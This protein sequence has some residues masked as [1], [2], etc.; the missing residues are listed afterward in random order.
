MDPFSTYLNK[1]R[2]QSRDDICQAAEDVGMRSR[3]RR[4]DQLLQHGHERRLGQR[5]RRGEPHRLRARRDLA[6]KDWIKLIN[7]NLLIRF[8]EQNFP[9]SELGKDYDLLS[10]DQDQKN[11]LILILDHFL[12]AW[13]DLDLILI[14]S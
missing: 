2:R 7:L 9:I 6:P 4:R 8:S 12:E 11:R 1:G 5:R 13:S 14:F 3:R 10:K